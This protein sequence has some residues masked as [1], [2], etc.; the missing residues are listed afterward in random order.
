MKSHKYWD[1]EKQCFD[2]GNIFS[3]VLLSVSQPNKLSYIKYFF[4]KIIYRIKIRKNKEV[5]F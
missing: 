5:P 2:T 1:R 3:D 4:W